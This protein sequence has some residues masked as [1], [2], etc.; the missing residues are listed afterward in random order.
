LLDR[1]HEVVH[2]LS[3]GRHAWLQV[4]A[5]SVALND[6]ELKQGD[7]AAVSGETNIRIVAREPAEVL[8]FDLA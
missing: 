4:A 8:L 1:D 2:G 6:I 3:S 5:G 7:G